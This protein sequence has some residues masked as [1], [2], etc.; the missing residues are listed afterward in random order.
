MCDGSGVQGGSVVVVGCADGLTVLSPWPQGP[1]PGLLGRTA[2]EPLAGALAFCV[3]FLHERRSDS[4]ASSSLQIEIEISTF[5]RV[6]SPAFFGHRR[7]SPQ[8]SWQLPSAERW[9]L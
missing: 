2:K 1:A 7:G 4:D 5:T 3:Q 6:I 8:G 9:V